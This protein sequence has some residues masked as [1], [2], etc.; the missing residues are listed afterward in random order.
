[1]TTFVGLTAK[2]AERR[3]REEGANEVVFT[4]RHQVLR[5]LLALWREPLFMLLFAA[6]AVYAWLGDQTEALALIASAVVAAVITIAQRVR[7]ER[8]LE[9]LRELSSPRASVIRDGHYIRIPARELVRDDC[10]VL[11][12]GDR[13]PA[14]ARLLDAENLVVDESVL[15]GESVAVAKFSGQDVRANTLVTS[16]VG[17]ATVTATGLRT[18]FGKIGSVLTQLSETVTPLQRDTASL[19]RTF[20]I[21]GVTLCILLAVGVGLKENDW[22]DGVLRGITLAMAVL[23]EE[24]PLII[25]V[26]FALGAQRLARHQVLTRRPGAIEALGSAAV[27]CV[28]KTGT[29]TMNKMRLVRAIAPHG[30]AFALK[31][32]AR[33][34]ALACEPE[35]FDPMER[36]CL[37]W[38]RAQGLAP[39]ED[40]ALR[41][42]YPM[43]ADCL[44]V[45]YAWATDAG[46]TVAVKGAPEHVLPS[47]ALSEAQQAHVIEQANAL[48]IAGLRV[49]AVARHE[50]THID[51]PETLQGLS[52]IYVGLIAFEDSL[53]EDVARAV[54][55]C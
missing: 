15:T 47:C 16:G 25:T 40:T 1:M 38:S 52:A 43:Q 7:A 19:A 4:T 18:A 46:M 30:T 10:I 24:F 37:E 26:F 51:P 8:V 49:L 54:A 53:R 3:L 32:L 33:I 13:V 27:L 48:A 17:H 11:R 14:D 21:T 31:D 2:E 42:R 5:A 20:G 22:L 29:L 9:A 36:A 41:R 39:L 35:P 12:E 45:G 44:R 34:T 50:F 28:D 55:E 23:P 6:S